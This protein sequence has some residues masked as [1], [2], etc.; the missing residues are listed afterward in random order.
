MKTFDAW[1]GWLALAALLL[2]WGCEA[3][4]LMPVA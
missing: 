2:A 1:I 4:W 3:R